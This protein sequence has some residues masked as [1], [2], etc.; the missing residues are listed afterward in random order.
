MIERANII[1]K[2]AYWL[3]ILYLLQKKEERDFF[4]S[5]PFFLRFFSLSSLLSRLF[6]F[7]FFFILRRRSEEKFALALC[8][9]TT[10]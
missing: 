9:W 5:I 2:I 7:L 4:V 8:L 6:F 1:G 10:P 3:A